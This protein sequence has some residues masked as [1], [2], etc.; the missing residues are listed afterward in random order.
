M[1]LVKTVWGKLVK[2]T[3]MWEIKHDIVMDS[4][5]RAKELVKKR[6]AKNYVSV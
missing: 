1:S 3:E 6:A 5:V 4:G 2:H